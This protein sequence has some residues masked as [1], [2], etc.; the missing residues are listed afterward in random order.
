MNQAHS[1]HHTNATAV[2]T[3]TGMDMIS[4]ET[5]SMGA[6]HDTPKESVPVDP[7]KAHSKAL[8]AAMKLDLRKMHALVGQQVDMKHR[9]F[10]HLCS[11]GYD[12]SKDAL[13]LQIFC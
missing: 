4:A 12:L 11:V 9:T 3:D 6:A 5:G 8:E 7:V 10:Q 2:G 1:E 13:L